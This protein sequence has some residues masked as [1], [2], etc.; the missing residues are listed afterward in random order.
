MNKIAWAVV[1]GVV[2]L[3]LISLGASLLFPF[4]WGRGFSGGMMG[5]WR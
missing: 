4:T 1:T 5:V 2:L 3:V